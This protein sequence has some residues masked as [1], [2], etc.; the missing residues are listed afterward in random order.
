M[1]ALAPGTPDRAAEWL[2]ALRAHC[3]RKLQPLYVLVDPVPGEPWPLETSD[4][5]Q[6]ADSS[7][8][9]R[10]RS[11]AWANAPIWSIP[12]DRLQRPMHQH[13]YLVELAGADDRLL[14]SSIEL[15]HEQFQELR[16]DGQTTCSAIG[17]WLS[18][19]ADPQ[20]LVQ[21]LGVLMQPH[22]PSGAWRYLRLFDPR[23]LSLIELLCGEVT[24]RR[25]IWPASIWHI[26][27]WQGT[28]R[29]YEGI[30]DEQFS[31]MQP[32]LFGAEAWL[33]LRQAE[34]IHRAL[35]AQ[36]KRDNNMNV[37]ATM[38]RLIESA[39]CLHAQGWNH[40]K[41]LIVFL[42]CQALYPGFEQNPNVQTTLRDARTKPGS[43]GPALQVLGDHLWRDL[44]PTTHNVNPLAN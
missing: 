26:V 27:S 31:P 34:P 36:L 40:P 8:L 20:A 6:E 5:I 11:R 29:S 1:M 37:S 41:D 12:L 28:I 3:L 24:L 2:D 43:L 23:V 30:E 38:R 16:S 22:E 35:A 39:R 10:L 44:G 33:T 4:A 18:T 15:A 17:G 7:T 9:R 14:L 25:M 21:R 42:L 13:P 19:G 32:W